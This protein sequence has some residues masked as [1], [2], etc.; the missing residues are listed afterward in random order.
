[1]KSTE[2]KK[3]LSAELK[4]FIS[5]AHDDYIK[6]SKLYDFLEKAGY[7]PWMDRKKLFGGED[8]SLA[9][10]KAIRDSQFFVA[11]LTNKSVDRAGV[12]QDE[13]QE[14]IDS[15]QNKHESDIFIIPVKL[16][17]CDIPQ[18]L[19][20]FQWIDIYEKNGF[21]KLLDSFNEGLKRLGMKV[22]QGSPFLMEFEWLSKKDTMAYIKR[23]ALFDSYENPNCKGIQHQYQLT[24]TGIGEKLIQDKA[25]KLSWQR[26]GSEKQLTFEEA[27]SYIEELNSIEY[28]RYK[29]WRLP[30]LM[31]AMS[32]LAPIDK[33][34]FYYVDPIFD[35][36]QDCIWTSSQY[37]KNRV[38][39]VD[40]E[41]GSYLDAE[42]L[43]INYVRAVRRMK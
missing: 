12:I 40:F 27:L 22:P 14:A 34:R 36:R 33:D 26:S 13:I 29:D 35:S 21:T 11:C 4:I 43:A 2:D 28:A 20:N 42:V 24:K 18:S 39:I 19:K 31:E 3:L 25:T 17:K 8:W 37:N 23:N 5:Y 9:I 38:W 10:R 15:W 30:S 16:E 6:V 32:L 7:Y 1:M 41:D